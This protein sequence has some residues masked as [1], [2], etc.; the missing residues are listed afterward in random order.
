MRTGTI[1]AKAVADYINACIEVASA[2]EHETDIIGA[3][4]TAVTVEHDGSMRITLDNGQ[5]ASFMVSVE[6]TD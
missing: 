5:T 2:P 4:I 3:L 6:A 1:A